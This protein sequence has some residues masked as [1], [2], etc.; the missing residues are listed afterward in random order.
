[1]FNLVMI[2]ATRITVCSL[3]T[4]ADGAPVWRAIAET[5]V[6]KTSRVHDL[7]N[8]PPGKAVFDARAKAVECVGA[9]RI[10]RA[11]TVEASGKEDTS[12]P[13]RSKR[14]AVRARGQ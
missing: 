3:R 12:H 6:H 8:L 2:R 10:Q 7:R 9:H 11:A 5:N 14:R 13:Q 1:M 4:C